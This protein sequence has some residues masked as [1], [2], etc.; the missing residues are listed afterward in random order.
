MHFR[1]AFRQ[2]TMVSVRQNFDTATSDNWK[3]NLLK[4]NLKKII[5][6]YAKFN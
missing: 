6:L 3:R 2:Q 1:T 4:G 5:S